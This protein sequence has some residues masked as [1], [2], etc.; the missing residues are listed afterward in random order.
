MKLHA[1][2]NKKMI[3][4]LYDY[5]YKIKWNDFYIDYKEGYY[6]SVT[7]FHQHDFYEVN[8]ILSGN[9]K[10]LFSDKTKET[11]NSCIV[12]TAPGTPHFI[13][14]M[15]DTLYSRIYLVFSHEFISN[16]VSEWQQLSQIFGN[17]GRIISISNEE[18]EFCKLLVKRI[19]S[20]NNSFRQK[21]LILYLLSYI[22]EFA[23]EK[24][25]SFAAIPDYIIDA[26]TYINNHYSEKI[27]ASDLAKRLNI[28][29]TTLMTA[30]KKHTGVTL[31]NYIIYHRLKNVIKYLSDGKSE[32][33]AA[34]LCGLNDS[35]SL[36]RCFKKYYKMTPLQYMNQSHNELIS[37]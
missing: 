1:K 5:G 2:G 12:L 30:F 23:L 37:L 3:N 28:S 14:C 35:S 20:E 10:I 8:I 16:S 4:A 26:L 11:N 6:T 15:P 36:I 19:E 27:V 33:E 25:A 7:G 31:N 24:E 13:S 22:S 29:R 34:E 21:L 17:T 18:K 9:T 32:Q